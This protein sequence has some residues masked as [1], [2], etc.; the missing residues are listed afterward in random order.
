MIKGFDADS[1]GF[2]DFEEFLTMIKHFMKDTR[3]SEA[4]NRALF[5][6]FD[7]N[8]D[9]CISVTELKDMLLEV[10]EEKTTADEIDMMIKAAD[11]DG[12]GKVDFKEF[13][14]VMSYDDFRS[15]DT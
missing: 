15:D 12:D 4:V 11:T 13:L 5:R 14:E 9:G 7:H 3:D 6:G 2:I 8:G 1:D 10:F